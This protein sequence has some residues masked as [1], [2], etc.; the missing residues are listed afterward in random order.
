MEFPNRIAGILKLSSPYKFKS[1][2]NKTEAFLFEPLDNKLPNFI[3]QSSIGK[4][5]N[6]DH[7]VIIQFLN[8][9]LELPRGN[10][11]QILGPITNEESVYKL[12]LFDKDIYPKTIKINSDIKSQIT[13]SEVDINFPLEIYSI[14]P[15][16]CRDIDD[17]FSYQLT[18]IELKL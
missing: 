7:A 8:H 3:V 4:S 5:S 12:H 1:T 13:L 16:K 17:A 15:E 9:D 18:D 6:E 2:N 14:D 11:L 10:I